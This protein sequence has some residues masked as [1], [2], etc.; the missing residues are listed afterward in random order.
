MLTVVFSCPWFIPKRTNDGSIPSLWTHALVYWV[1]S[2]QCFH[3]VNPGVLPSEHRFSGAF[4][5]FKSVG[6]LS[7]QLLQSQPWDTQGK[8]KIQTTH[9]H[10]G[11]Q[12]LGLNQSVIFSLFSRVII[13]F[14]HIQCSPLYLERMGGGGNTTILS[15][16]SSLK[17]YDIY[18][19]QDIYISPDIYCCWCNH[20]FLDTCNYWW[21]E[22]SVPKMFAVQSWGSE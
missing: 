22:H 12:I 18:I 2:W 3:I 13:F 1:S 6:I 9:Q 21:P 14:Y 15:T 11:S 7:Y 10:S 5:L 20:L 8:M 19:S 17:E 16:K 4:L